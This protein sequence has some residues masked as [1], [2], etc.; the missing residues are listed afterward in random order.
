MP[1]DPSARKD[2]EWSNPAVQEL[3]TLLAANFYFREDVEQVVE[4]AG[5]PPGKIKWHLPPDQVWRSVFKVADDQRISLVDDVLTAASK[6]KPSLEDRIRSLRSASPILGAPPAPPGGGGHGGWKGGYEYI[7]GGESTLLDMH[8]LQRAIEAATAVCK[9]DVEYPSGDKAWASGFAIAPD[10][11]LTNRHALYYQMRDEDRAV[12][13][14]ASFF[15]ETGKVPVRVRGLVDTIARH[16]TLDCAI[17]RLERAIE[18]VHPLRLEPARAPRKGDPA[19]IIQHPGGGLKQLG[20]YRNE[21]RHVDDE[22]V[23]YLTDTEGGSSGSPVCNREWDVIAVHNRYIETAE[24]Q[25][26]GGAKVIAR[27][28]Q[29]VRIG[30]VIPWLNTLGISLGPR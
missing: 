11:L 19:F 14:D 21:I 2:I 23:Q 13:V 20:L 28:N 4:T 25:G 22:V 26:P 1:N 7:L 29:G 9:L 15:A 12:A 27:R 10:L 6:A 16:P 8:F 5:V 24:S 30:P 17:L 3:L 18:G